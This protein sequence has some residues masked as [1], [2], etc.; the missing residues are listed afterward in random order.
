MRIPGFG[1]RPDDTLR[2]LTYLAFRKRQRWA[3][4]VLRIR[5]AIS[6][7]IQGVYLVILVQ[8]AQAL[9]R[10]DDLSLRELVVALL[11]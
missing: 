6:T 7:A 11:R 9:F 1:R 4:R 3:R 5:L 2:L 10:N 8:V